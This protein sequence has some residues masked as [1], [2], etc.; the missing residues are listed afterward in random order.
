VE[1]TIQRYS[2]DNWITEQIVKTDFQGRSEGQ[3]VL[4]T[5]YYNFI[6]RY[7]DIV[8]FGIPNDDVNKKLI[9]AEDVTNG[10]LFTIDTF[11]TTDWD[12]SVY[13]GTYWIISNLTYINTS[14]TGG[15]FYYHYDDIN[16]NVWTACL[17]VKKSG[18]YDIG[19]YIC[20]C[21]TNSVT[22]ESSTLTCIV[23]QTTGREVYTAV[24]MMEGS[25]PFLEDIMSITLGMDI[26]IDWSVTGYLIGFFLVLLS[27]FL[28]LKV[29]T[30]SL[31]VGTGVFALLISLGLMFK[32]IGYTVLITLLVITYLVAS[33]KSE[34]G[35][36][37]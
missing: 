34:S 3:F 7:L 8:K 33:I 14:S 23:N 36:N 13:Q 27:Y 35:I 5:V 29:P 2:E 9:Y 10:L 19:N 18:S 21:S 30:I 4:S 11:G 1:V 16:N 6:L 25:G 28:F 24:V 31:Y 37:G 26:N 32:D 15:Y 22:S 17:E 20:N 12:L